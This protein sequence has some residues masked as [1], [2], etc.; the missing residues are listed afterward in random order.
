MQKILDAGTFLDNEY[1]D[2]R[3]TI[4][5]YYTNSI[6]IFKAFLNIS[7]WT[8]VLTKH[9]LKEHNAVKEILFNNLDSSCYNKEPCCIVFPFN[10]LFID[11]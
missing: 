1:V 5:K 8:V 6:S 3:A 2:S 11:F 9:T 7:F 4:C 10:L